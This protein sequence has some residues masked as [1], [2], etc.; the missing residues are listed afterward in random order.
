VKKSKL[1]QPKKIKKEAADDR[2][3]NNANAG[4]GESIC[5]KEDGKTSNETGNQPSLR[6][7]EEDNSQEL[8]SE[9]R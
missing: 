7:R 1:P 4:M 9:S 8:R 5:T 3:N 2:N 6:D